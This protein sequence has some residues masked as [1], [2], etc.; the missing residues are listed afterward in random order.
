MYNS[1]LSAYV[2]AGLEIERGA[3]GADRSGTRSPRL[4]LQSRLNEISGLYIPECLALGHPGKGTSASL[5]PLGGV[6]SE[7]LSDQ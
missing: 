1:A 2:R 5:S 3:V 6:V 7:P 4:R